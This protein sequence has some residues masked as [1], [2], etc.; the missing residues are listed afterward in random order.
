MHKR[1]IFRAGV[2]LIGVALFVLG[3][4]VGDGRI[5]WSTSRNGLPAQLD[6]S[7]VNQVYQDLKSQYYGT[8]TT[9][10]L[11]NG[12]KT[13]MV[14]AVGDPYTEYFTP[15]QAKAFN[16]DLNGSFGGIG[17]ELGE[18]ASN[19]LEIIAPL[20]G[21]PADKAGLKPND[22][23]TSINGTNT[24]GMSIDAAV[25]KIRGPVNSKVT[26]GITRGGAQLTFTIVRANITPPSVTYKTLSGNIG[27]MQISQFSNDTS[28]L[29][30]K[31]AQSFQQAH[32]KGVILDLRNDPGGLVDAAVNVSSLWLPSGQEIMQERAGSSVLQTY[33]STGNDLLK[34]IPTVVLI[35]SGSASAAEITTGAL[36][37]NH[38]AY[39]IGEKSYGKGVVQ[40][41][42]N[43][44]DGSELKV[45]IASW[46]RPDGQNINHK[47]IQ[48]DQTVGLT[49]AQAAAGQDPQL[50]AAEAY[51]QK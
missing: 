20:A 41:L 25:A 24:T 19:Q 1:L 14:N 11:L 2:L 37:D 8:L 6:Y 29:A 5:S 42:D 28:G 39:V 40:Q 50:Q 30:E 31:A 47:G 3:I 4:F 46:Y 7:S 18:N 9:T 22:L 34:G 38:A 27:Y 12:M 35:N 48:P 21:T 33:Y 15:S 16:N 13:G 45:T 49:D 43:L 36:H 44:S 26:L 17:A 10:Q 23:I 32:V 51:L